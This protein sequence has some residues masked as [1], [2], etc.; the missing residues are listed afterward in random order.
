ME[1]KN[2]GIALGTAIITLSVLIIL[3][4]AMSLMA[5]SAWRTSRVLSQHDVY[6]YALEG[7]MNIAALE[8]AQTIS[9]MTQRIFMSNS[10]GE[11][12]LPVGSYGGNWRNSPV[13]ATAANNLLDMALLDFEVR[14]QDELENLRESIQWRLKHNPINNI[15]VH[16]GELYYSTPYR[17]FLP[18]GTGYYIAATVYK[19][20]STSP[21][22]SDYSAPLRINSSTEF[23]MHI[24]YHYTPGFQTNELTAGFEGPRGVHTNWNYLHG[25]FLG[26][27][28]GDMRYSS[29]VNLPSS[30]LQYFVDPGGRLI[31]AARNRNRGNMLSSF[32]TGDVMANNFYMPL[33][34]NFVGLPL[35][36]SGNT[37]SLTSTMH[38]V[39]PMGYRLSSGA[40]H[41]EGWRSFPARLAF[42]IYDGPSEHNMR[43]MVC[44]DPANCPLSSNGFNCFNTCTVGDILNRPSH[45]PISPAP[46]QWPNTP[47]NVQL[48]E[49]VRGSLQWE[50]MNESIGV[51][52]NLWHPNH[53]EDSDR[54]HPDHMY[55]LFVPDAN[56][57]NNGFIN[58]LVGTGVFGSLQEL[59][60]E[61]NM[62]V[63]WENVSLRSEETTRTSIGMSAAAFGQRGHDGSAEGLHPY[64]ANPR[65]ASAEDYLF[66]LALLRTI[67]QNVTARD[68]FYPA[69]APLPVIA[70]PIDG[71][72]V[73]SEIYRLHGRAQYIHVPG[74][75]YITARYCICEDCEEGCDPSCNPHGRFCGE[76]VPLPHFISRQRYN[77]NMFV[78]PNLRLLSV[79]GDIIVSG[80]VCMDG[81]IT[82]IGRWE[83]SSARERIFELPAGHESRARDDRGTVV[84]ARNFIV[85]TPAF[86]STDLF[87]LHVFA[88]NIEFMTYENA[89]G[90][91]NITD[92]SYFAITYPDGNSSVHKIRTNS[93]FVARYRIYLGLLG[94]M[95]IRHYLGIRQIGEP[96][97]APQLF[98]TH[99]CIRYTG[100]EDNLA[101]VGQRMRLYAFIVSLEGTTES[102]QFGWGTS[103]VNH[104]LLSTSGFART[105]NI[106]T[107]ISFNNSMGN[108]VNPYTR[109]RNDFVQNI[110]GVTVAMFN[111]FQGV[112][113]AQ[114]PHILPRIAFSSLPSPFAY[115][116]TNIVHER[117][118]SAFFEQERRVP[119]KNITCPDSGI[120]LVV[121]D[122]THWLAGFIGLTWD[123]VLDFNALM[124]IGNMTAAQIAR[125]DMYRS[126]RILPDR[127]ITGGYGIGLGPDN[128]MNMSFNMDLWPEGMPLQLYPHDSRL[129]RWALDF[130]RPGEI[131]NTNAPGGYAIGRNPEHPVGSSYNALQWIHSDETHNILNSEHWNDPNRG[132]HLIPP[133]QLDSIFNQNNRARPFLYRTLNDIPLPGGVLSPRNSSVLFLFGDTTSTTVTQVRR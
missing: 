80:G 1:K 74:D 123:E 78:F 52:E 79:A 23:R 67:R 124:P 83:E 71:K 81:G 43:S 58:R 10:F 126:M 76:N 57:R 77:C 121:V 26:S 41:L 22:D 64:L 85:G 4:S 128:Y 112:W 15:V 118:T 31:V 9:L 16:L 47:F 95:G 72:F 109:W 102:G 101:L 3:A 59:S 49:P 105:P 34:F 8:T 5:S 99:V 120:Q 29:Q 33:S 122:D 24:Y 117:V 32:T 106:F 131:P 19:T 86:S 119:T 38:R 45:W 89:F 93:T 63:P 21:L 27:L 87:N 84:L 127:V 68:V 65:I 48:R 61:R 13:A 98:A 110:G 115:H 20:V 54:F 69:V 90:L 75:L 114:M 17:G 97:M 73:L 55:R 133:T 35:P 53:D 125:R 36:Y 62:R 56:L 103:T 108:T 50:R 116:F 100:P 14:L 12:S 113:G 30:E 82:L 94:T 132:Y 51:F 37:G 2:K 129:G 70:V 25:S 88:D 40:L 104:W 66:Q 11:I 46:A 111:G 96:H 7:G 60:R 6:W 39:L 18:Y 42:G 91:R 130:R 92:G 107:R 44:R 28:F